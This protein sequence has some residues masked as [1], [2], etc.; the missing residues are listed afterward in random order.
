MGQLLLIICI[1]GIHMEPFHGIHVE[2]FHGIHMESFHGIHMESFHGIHVESILT[3]SGYK[4]N[5]YG[6]HVE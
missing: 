4:W 2:P 6:I 3:Y 5:P 1:L